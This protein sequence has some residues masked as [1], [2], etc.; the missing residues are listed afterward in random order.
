MNIVCVLKSG[1]D[2]G[3]RYIKN[4]SAGVAEHLT[5]LDYRFV[6]HTDM[7]LPCGTFGAGVKWNHIPLEHDLPGWWSKLEA[8]RTTGPSLYLDLDTYVAGNLDVGVRALATQLMMGKPTDTFHMLK[9]FAQSQKWAS[10]V[11]AWSGDWSWLLDALTPDD[12]AEYAWDQ[13][14][15]STS[16]EARGCHIMP[17]QRY[18]PSIRSYKHHCQDGVPDNTELVCF[19][20]HPRPHEVGGEF[21]K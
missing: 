20:G 11:M 10:G 7:V 6:V 21:Y 4:L 13:R 1:G 14:Y 19:H 15:I 18:I 12:I 8:F 3:P 17:I 2:Y 5:D 16:V 9:P